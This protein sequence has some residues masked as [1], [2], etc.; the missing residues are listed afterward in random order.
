MTKAERTAAARKAGKK[1]WPKK[2]GKA[3]TGGKR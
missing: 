1:R 3:S 2:R